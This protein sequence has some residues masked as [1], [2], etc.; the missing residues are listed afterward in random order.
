[1]TYSDRNHDLKPRPPKATVPPA[2]SETLAATVERMAT[3][4]ILLDVGLLAVGE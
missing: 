2:D 3:S 1:M 4:F